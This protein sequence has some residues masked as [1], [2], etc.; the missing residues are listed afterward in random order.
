MSAHERDRHG[1]RLDEL[2]ARSPDPQASFEASALADCAECREL[3]DEL[4]SIERR[5]EHMAASE[6]QGLAAYAAETRDVRPGP[7]EA[8]FEQLVRGEL[9]RQPDGSAEPARPR[10]WAWLV[11]AAALVLVPLLWRPWTQVADPMLGAGLLRPIGEV[12]GSRYG[13]FEWDVSRP[14]NGW[15]EVTVEYLTEDGVRKETSSGR[16]LEPRWLPD[17]EIERLWPD[18]IRWRLET[19]GGSGSM[20]DG[21]QSASASRSR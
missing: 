7:A 10:R 19:Y 11:A 8:H 9:A 16:I 21:T 12:Q 15:F 6:R 1:E 13:P 3:A 5:L 18:H 14:D 2:L 4:R 17:P 20:P